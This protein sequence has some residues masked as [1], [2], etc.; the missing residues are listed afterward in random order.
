MFPTVSARIQGGSINGKRRKVPKKPVP[1][2]EGD[3]IVELDRKTTASGK[4][5]RRSNKRKAFRKTEGE[6]SMDEITEEIAVKKN[7]LSRSRKPDIGKRLE[8]ET[9][10]AADDVQVLCVLPKVKVSFMLLQIPK[11]FFAPSWKFS[12]FFLPEKCC[13]CGLRP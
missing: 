5:K 3:N 4:P 10:S 7:Q 2:G 6:M 12:T 1:C 13:R 9:K 11:I 8:A